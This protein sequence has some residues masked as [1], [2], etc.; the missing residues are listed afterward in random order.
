MSIIQLNEK[1]MDSVHSIK[2]FNLYENTFHSATVASQL[3][4]EESEALIKTFSTTASGREKES[5]EKL[6]YWA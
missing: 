1:L 6:D 4:R 3:S 5:K 2:R